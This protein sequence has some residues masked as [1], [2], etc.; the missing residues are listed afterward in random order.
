V[1]RILQARRVFQA[2][3]TD[4]SGFISL[5]AWCNAHC[6]S[7]S[8]SGL[9]RDLSEYTRGHGDTHA[10]TRTKVH[11]H[12]HKMYMHTDVHT[13]MALMCMLSCSGTYIQ[14][15]QAYRLSDVHAG[16]NAHH[17]PM[18]TRANEKSGRHR[19]AIALMQMHTCNHIHAQMIVHTPAHVHT[20]KRACMPA[21]MHAYMHICVHACMPSC[22][23]AYTPTCLHA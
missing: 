23:H 9:E 22:L 6:K 17:K 18:L 20:C 5:E 1:P 11:T 2:I 7:G 13:Y 16:T 3:D 21:C 14:H 8:V 12:R 4:H 19:H 15:T 10:N